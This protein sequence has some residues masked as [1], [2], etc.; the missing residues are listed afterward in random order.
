MNRTFLGDEIQ[1]EHGFGQ[2]E[3]VK[4]S[5]RGKSLSEGG[6]DEVTNL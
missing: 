3:S 6:R 2:K 5:G 1:N 4:W